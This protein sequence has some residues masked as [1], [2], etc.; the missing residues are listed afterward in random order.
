MAFMADPQVLAKRRIAEIQR[1][2]E[3]DVQET[4]ERTEAAQAYAGENEKHFVEFV[5]DCVKTSHDAMIEIRREQAECWATY[6][7]EEPANYA[8]KEDWQSKVIIP[9]P[10]GAVQFAMSVVRKAFDVQFLSVENK[11]DPEAAE[12]WKDLMTIQLSRNNANFPIRFT[13]ASGMGFAIGQSMEMIPIWRPGKGLTYNL[14]EPWKIYRDPDSLSREPQSGMYWVHREWLDYYVLREYEKKGRY[15]NVLGLAGS[16]SQTDPIDPN[17]SRSAIDQRKGHTWRR[18]QFR[19]MILVSEFYGTVLSPNGELLL[20]SSRYTIAEGKVIQLPKPVPYPNLRWPGMS[21]S[22]IPDFLRF[23]GRGILQGVRRM[24]EFMCSLLCLHNDG[25]NWLV[26]PPWEMNVQGLVDPQDTE[27]YPGKVSLTRETT[28]GQQVIRSVDRRGTTSDV[29]ANINFGAQ[30]FEEGTFVAS[31]VRGLPGYRAEVTARE[32]AQNLDQAM[33]VFSL[34]GKN[35]EDGALY[36]ILAGAETVAINITMEELIACMGRERAMRYADP[37]SEFGVKL[38]P[39][40]GGTFS[41]SGISALMRDSEIIKNIQTTILPLYAQGS[42]FVPY[43]KPYALLKCL[44]TRLNLTDEGILVTEEQAQAIDAKQQTAQESEIQ[45]SQ[46]AAEAEALR[47]QNEAQAIPA[48]IQNDQQANL[49][50]QQYADTEG[51]YAQN[52]QDQI[53]AQMQQAM[54][55]QESAQRQQALD[56]L[57]QHR[58]HQHEVARGNSE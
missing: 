1:Q 29:L 16:N 20:P 53:A 35:L 32:S 48:Q 11:Q 2:P 22:P 27:I 58:Q 23:D 36:A 38:P 10:F 49:I 37:S 3:Y 39:L 5:N 4:Q 21:F 7:E 56:E 41:V 47:A 55:N 34:I 19:N 25:L 8:D 46:Q 14:V 26:N 6:K 50:E 9:K 18:S 15:Q 17:N 12:F 57:M 33:T 54:M 13:D 30:S 44:E 31:V 28:S 24:W 40:T 45:S 42:V 43:L 51:Q 52:E